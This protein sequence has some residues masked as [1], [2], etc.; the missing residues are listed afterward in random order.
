MSPRAAW[1]L[2]ELDFEHVHDY[3][4][5]KADWGAAGL[6]LEGSKPSNMRVGA[7]TRRET[8]TCTP[9][10]RLDA[11]RDRAR[12]SGLET[13]IVLNH[14]GIV[15]GRIGRRHLTG[16]R[17]ATARDAMRLGPSTVRPDLLLETAV[18]RM[19]TTDLASLL[20]TTSDGRLVGLLPRTDAERILA[21]LTS[22]PPA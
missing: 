13:C 9:D 14:A 19:R 22:D 2:A 21:S 7:H 5:G 17:P 1:R 12:T 20:V 3:T 15:I 10:E 6:P 16:N 4:D 11:A 8:P 18:E